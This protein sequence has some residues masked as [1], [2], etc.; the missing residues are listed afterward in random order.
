[1]VWSWY[2]GDLRG[3]LYR[4]KSARS[5]I[6][7]GLM[8]RRL[9]LRVEIGSENVSI[10]VRSSLEGSTSRYSLESPGGGMPLA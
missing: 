8:L 9:A 1:M 4:I 3:Q 5:F 7:M 10:Y 2:I 6:C